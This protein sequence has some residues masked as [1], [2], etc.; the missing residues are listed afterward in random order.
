MVGRSLTRQQYRQWHTESESGMQV[1]TSRKWD[2]S[3]NITKVGCKWQH[4]ESGMW[5]DM[6]A[7]RQ[8]LRNN[9]DV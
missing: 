1:A 6:I 9:Q 8:R 4:H 5:S 2:A 3:G 7:L